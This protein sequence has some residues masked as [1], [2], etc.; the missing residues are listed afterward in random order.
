[1]D[2]PIAWFSFA[3]N[4]VY[5][6]EEPFFFN[7]NDKPWRKLIEDNYDVILSE[8][9]QVINSNTKNIIPYFNQNLATNPTSWTILPLMRWKKMY[10]INCS[11]CPKTIEI[12][13]SIKGVTSITFSV[14]KPHT[15]IKPHF[16]DSNVMYRCHFTLK[17]L[18]TLP[19]IGMRVG[20]EKTSWKNG[21]LIAFCD[22]YNHEVWNDTD[23][24][25]W[26]LIID[27]LREDFL[28]DEKTICNKVNATL[29]WQLKFQNFYFIK[30]LPRWSRKWLMNLTAL[31]MK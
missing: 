20:N 17:C 21:K 29:W 16:G 22:A 14:L 24:E 8:F 10:D 15:K 19:E 4:A 7:I 5:N 11:F 27:I 13:N 1:M 3:E 23:D 6:G 12:L 28:K 25:R 2:K 30:H 18:N 31:F 26:I 9:N